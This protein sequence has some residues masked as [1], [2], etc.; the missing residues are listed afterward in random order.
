MVINV[1]CLIGLALLLTGCGGGGQ[2]IPNVIGLIPIAGYAL[3][4]TVGD[5]FSSDGA[6]RLGLYL[7]E[8]AAT[9]YDRV[10]RMPY[11]EP[12]GRDEVGGVPRFLGW[13]DVLRRKGFRLLTILSPGAHEG[14]IDPDVTE[15][16]IRWLL[17]QIADLLVGV[18]LCNEQWMIA[19]GRNRRFEPEEFAAYHNRLSPVIRELAPNLPIVEGDF[20]EPV[21]NERGVLCDGWSWWQQVEAAGIRNVDIVS[22][23]VW[24]TNRR[25][26]MQRFQ[27]IKA[28][29]GNREYWITECDRF[30]HLEVGRAAGLQ[31]TRCF[32][33]SWN[34]TDSF[35]RR[36]GGAILA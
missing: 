5:L 16:S 10:I 11:G 21:K 15:R 27:A 26:A 14:E 34:G 28:A 1:L 20:F 36:L 18:Q 24:N 12:W 25:E 6:R 9:G 31:I 22:L 17:P 4:I 33:Y 29:L 8:L 35:A 7:D 30:G 23:H 32:L 3:N 13:V 19:G 2:D